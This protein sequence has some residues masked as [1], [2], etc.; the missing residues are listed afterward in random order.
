LDDFLGL[1]ALGELFGKTLDVDM[2]FT[3]QHDV[4]R[5][6]IA[7]LDPSFICVKMDVMIK[8]EFFKLRFEVEGGT[9]FG[10]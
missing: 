2:D 10:S 4:L 7:C 3:H 9:T 5:I 6:N 8:D 1:W